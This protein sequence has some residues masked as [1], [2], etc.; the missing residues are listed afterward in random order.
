[1]NLRLLHALSEARNLLL[2]HA[3]N[4][5][6]DGQNIDNEIMRLITLLEMVYKK[7]GNYDLPSNEELLNNLDSF[8][9]H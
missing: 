3:I 9:T 6:N 5:I 4:S 8:R 2:I 7:W 1:M